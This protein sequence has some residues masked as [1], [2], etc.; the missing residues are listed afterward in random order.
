MGWGR[1]I[2]LCLFLQAIDYELHNANITTV[3]VPLNG[4]Y[5]IMYG[6]F[7]GGGGVITFWIRKLFYFKQS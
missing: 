6:P 1:W 4:L 2:V 5:F 7:R 3:Y